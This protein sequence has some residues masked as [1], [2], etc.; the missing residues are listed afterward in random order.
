MSSAKAELT[1]QDAVKNTALHLA[2]SKVSNPTWRWCSLWFEFCLT[3]LT[4]FLKGHET[5]AL[6][7][8]EKITDRNLINSTNAALQT[9][10][11]FSCIN[12]A[13]GPWSEE[14]HYIGNSVSLW[15]DIVSYLSSYHLRMKVKCHNPNDDDLFVFSE[16]NTGAL[17][18]FQGYHSVMIQKW[19]VTLQWHSAVS[20]GPSAEQRLNYFSQITQILTPSVTELTTVTQ[21]RHIKIKVQTKHE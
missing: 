8:L 3:C 14:V 4:L 17:K 2:C 15:T 16:D 6:L 11:W 1:L 10:V 18:P 19:F 21:N 13:I 12:W 7:I 20:R 5:S 9:Y